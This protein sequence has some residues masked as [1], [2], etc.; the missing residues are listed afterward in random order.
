MTAYHPG[1]FG[2][3]PFYRLL[4]KETLDAMLLYKF[5][6]FYHAHMVK[7]AI[8]LIEGLQPATGKSLAFI[9][10]PYK[11]FP[12]QV[13]VFCHKSAVLTAW[14]ATGAVCLPDSLLFHVFFHRQIAGANGAVH[15][16]RGN[17]LFFHLQQV[18]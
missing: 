7:G 13:A 10:E 17:E 5:E 12:Q 6:V 2:A 11:P 3:V 18:L 14:A 16:A 4:F 15:P 1:T 8:A 9:A